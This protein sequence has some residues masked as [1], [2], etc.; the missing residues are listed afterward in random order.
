MVFVKIEV[1][2]AEVLITPEYNN[3]D[4]VVSTYSYF[5]KLM[6]NNLMIITQ[7]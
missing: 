6:Q 1:E 5:G 7:L 3:Y 2:A 4:Q